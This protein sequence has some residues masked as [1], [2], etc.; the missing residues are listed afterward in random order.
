MQST[1]H[2]QQIASIKQEKRPLSALEKKR[3]GLILLSFIIVCVFWMSFEQAGGL[4]TVYSEKYTN[5]LLM[6]WEIPAS[7]F[8]SL[9]PLFIIV[10]GGVVAML[11]N[12]LAGR[13]KNP[14][15]IFKMGLGTV[16][17]G[18]GFVFMVGASLQR[19]S[20]GHS[21]MYWLV[22]AYLFHTIGELCLS[23]VS[24][25]F[26]TKVA[27][28]HK[29]ATMIGLYFA[30]TGIAQKLAAEIGKMSIQLGEYAIFVGLVILPISLGLLLMFFSKRLTK[31]TGGLED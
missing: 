28:K 29:V 26:I 1:A 24:L 31:M 13:N 16:I 2:K 20:L 14:N 25:S 6:G 3:I 9:N 23:P 8:Q 22:F 18:M 11:W 21:A 15:S 19:H 4:M 30:V 12:W 27:P 5:R 17:M 7:W 10:F